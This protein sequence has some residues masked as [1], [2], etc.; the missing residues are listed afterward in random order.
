MLSVWLL[1][2]CHFPTVQELDSLLL[3]CEELPVF[4]V[5]AQEWSDG[6]ESL[7]SSFVHKCQQLVM[8]EARPAGSPAARKPVPEVPSLPDLACRQVPAS[9][10][11]T[12]HSEETHQEE[13]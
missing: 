2:S 12:T 5:Q 6:G 9:G 4:S 7:T 11:R 1:V 8:D 3:R 13:K 10:N